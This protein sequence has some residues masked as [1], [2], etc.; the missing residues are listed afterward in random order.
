MVW[1]PARWENRAGAWIFVE[2][3]WRWAAPPQPTA[4]YEPSVAPAQP[5]YAAA[6]PPAPVAEVQGVPPFGGAVWIP[7]YWHWHGQHY[8]WVGGRW[9]APRAGWVWEPHHWERGPGGWRMAPGHWRH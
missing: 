4:Y 9:S 1:E 3:H 7:G 8:Q 2:G 6:E 5:V